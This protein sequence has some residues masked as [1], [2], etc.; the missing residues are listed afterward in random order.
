MNKP[1]SDWQYF[2]NGAIGYLVGALTFVLFIFLVTQFGVIKGLINQIDESQDLVRLLAVPVLAGLMLAI[3]GAILGG[4]GGWAVTRIIRTTRKAD[5]VIGSAIAF[6]VSTS[7]L[8]LVFLLVIGF[9]GLYNN[10]ASDRI[11][12]YGLI[13]G[14]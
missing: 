13:C 14:L 9:L 12:Q 4:V 5:L 7:V 11:E 2:I 3:G 6:A 1:Q 10:M 8:S